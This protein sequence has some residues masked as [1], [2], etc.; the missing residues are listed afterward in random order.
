VKA[1]IPLS[2]CGL[3]SRVDARRFVGCL[4]EERFDREVGPHVRPRL[5]G[6]QRYYRVEELRAWIDMD[7]PELYDDSKDF[8]ERVRRAYSDEGSTQTDVERARVLLSPRDRD[9]VTQ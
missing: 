5:I 9:E 2:D 4:G 8:M 6:N 1:R 7:R 3:L